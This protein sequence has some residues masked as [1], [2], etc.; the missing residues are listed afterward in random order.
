MSIVVWH[1]GTG[2]AVRDSKNPDGFMW[3]SLDPEWAEFIAEVKTGNL[4][5]PPPAPGWPGDEIIATD[6]VVTED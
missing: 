4:D 5:T 6:V 1:K 2:V 3:F